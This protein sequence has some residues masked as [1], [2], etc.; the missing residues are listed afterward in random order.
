MIKINNQTTHNVFLVSLTIYLL[1]VLTWYFK[2]PWLIDHLIY[3]HVAT[4][5]NLEDL[6]FWNLHRFSL[7]EGHYNERWAV[8]VPIMLFNKIFFFFKP[9]TTSLILIVLI[10]LLIFYLCFLFL[11][12]KENNLV[13]ILFC[14]FFVLAVHHTKNRTTEILADSFAIFY[15]CLIN[16]FVFCSKKFKKNFNFNIGLLILLPALCKIHYG[17]F[18]YFLESF[19]GKI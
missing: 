10:H 3:L 9:A 18:S 2:P 19:L 12:I 8:L 11:K 5:N 7:P 14:I 1:I 17:I 6:N 4:P 15:I 13:T 16:Y